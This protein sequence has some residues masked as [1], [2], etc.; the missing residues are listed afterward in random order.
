MKQ[1][2]KV[3]YG[4]PVAEHIL[5]QAIRNNV[6]GKELKIISI[7]NDYASEVYMR[8]KIKTCEK[9]G[10]LAEHINLVEEN[11]EEVGFK[12][13]QMYMDSNVDTGFLLQ[14]PTPS[15]ELDSLVKEI[16]HFK[17]VDG[18]SSRNSF[19]VLQN[20]V[21]AKV[22]PC[23]PNGI[24]EMLKFYNISVAGKHCVIVGRSDIV[25][26]PLMSILLSMDATVSVCH[27][28]TS[29]LKGVTTQAD[30]LIVAVGAPELV[31]EDYIKAGA[32]II[33]VGINRNAEGNLCGDVD[34]ESCKK[35]AYAIS[36][37]PKGVGVTTTASVVYNLSVLN[38]ELHYD[39]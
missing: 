23:T 10:V 1:E 17:D 4:Q 28:K 6:K 2:C 19:D 12:L 39:E 25:G 7:G 16:P 27:S 8:N 9:V 5:E 11:F 15:K 32:V 18:L 13:E 36:P 3:L 21:N 35:K 37:V 31:T 34:F 29:N 26:K 22:L 30:I 24:I 33:D 14:L 38:K 20:G